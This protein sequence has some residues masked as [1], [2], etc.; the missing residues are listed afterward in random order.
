MCTLVKMK[1]FEKK[2]RKIK[3][4][5]VAHII[6]ALCGLIILVI[7]GPIVDPDPSF[8]LCGII[9]KLRLIS[10]HSWPI[11]FWHLWYCLKPMPIL[12][13]SWL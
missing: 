7:V 3:R 2:I 9:L 4:D 12:A 11:L 5:Q 1:M 6:L 13:H 8:G 10:A